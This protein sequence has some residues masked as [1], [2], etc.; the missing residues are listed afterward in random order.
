MLEQE[1][2]WWCPLS[3]WPVD[4]WEALQITVS[5]ETDRCAL[6]LLLSLISLLERYKEARWHQQG[7]NPWKGSKNATLAYWQFTLKTLEN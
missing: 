3:H 4:Q 7:G 1:L 5:Q 2:L 6:A